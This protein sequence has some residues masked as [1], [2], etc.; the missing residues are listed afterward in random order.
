MFNNLIE[1]KAKRQRSAGGMLWS[2]VIHTVIITGAVYGTLK[3][4]QQIEKVQQEKVEFVKMEKKEPPPPKPKA[5]PPPDVT[6]APPPPKGFQV[7]TA[8][9]KIPDVLPKIDLSKSVTNAADFSGKGVAGGIAKGV[10]GGTAPVNEG[11]TF[12]AFQV[13]KQVEMASGNQAPHYPDIL[14]SANV[15]GEVIAQFV[16]DT[17]GRADMSTFKV[18]KSTHDLFTAAV[19]NALRDY[20]FYPAEIGGRKVKQLVQQPFQFSLNH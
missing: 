2:L 5:P 20:R 17:N 13:E 6:A 16:V 14:R 1:S 3:A 15:E 4:G 11:N 19:K 18:L 10:V 8:P 9:I 7:L 12:F